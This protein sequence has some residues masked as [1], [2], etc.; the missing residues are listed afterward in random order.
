M[1]MVANF[2][3]RFRDR[4]DFFVVTRN[5]DSRSNRRPFTEVNSNCWQDHEDAKVFYVPDGRWSRALCSRLFDDVDPAVVFLNSIFST[6]VVKFLLTRRFGRAR[7][8]PV[9]LAPCGELAHEALHIKSHRKR[10][11]LALAKAFGLYSGIIWKSSTEVESSEIRRHFGQKITVRTAPDLPSPARPMSEEADSKAVKTPGSVSLTFV[12][13][14]VR[15]KN[16][17]YLLEVLARIEHGSV[18]LTIV[19]PVEDREYWAKCQKLIDSLPQN[20]QVEITGPVQHEAVSDILTGSHFLVHPTLNENFGYVLLEG[21]AAGCPV[22]VSDRT[23]W[24]GI[25]EQNAGFVLPLDDE[26]VWLET[27]ER[28]ICMDAASYRDMSIGARHF[29]EHFVAAPEL[30]ASMESLVQEALGSTT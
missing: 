21:L 29:A 20:I 1:R 7:N 2:A 4:Y 5:Y 19:G 22:I 14:I 28:C 16:L 17:H 3:A 23:S 25:T 26:D 18:K 12:A 27:I 30:D 13:R 6:P 11:F 8:V 24:R 10:A 15:I 9:I